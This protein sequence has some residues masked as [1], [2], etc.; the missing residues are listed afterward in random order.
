MLQTQNRF[1]TKLPV[2]KALRILKF[3]QHILEPHLGKIHSIH[4]RILSI[5]ILISLFQ[6][7]C[8]TQETKMYLIFLSD[9]SC[10]HDTRMS[11]VPAVEIA[12]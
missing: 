8:Y 3:L 1:S 6:G 4:T 9:Q 12:F 10:C 11:H 7:L 5:Q 2:F